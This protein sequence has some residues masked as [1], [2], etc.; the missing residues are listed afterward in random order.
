MYSCLFIPDFI[1]EL[2]NELLL[3]YVQVRL[4]DGTLTEAMPRISETD[5]LTSQHRIAVFLSTH[6]AYELLPESGKVWM[7]YH[8]LFSLGLHLSAVKL[9]SNELYCILILI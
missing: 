6:T 4:T 3:L 9:Y 1:V 7:F 8:W 2:L 5:V